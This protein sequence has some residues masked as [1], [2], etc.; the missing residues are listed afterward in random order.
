MTDLLLQR[1]S[2]KQTAVPL[3][4]VVACVVSLCLAAFVLGAD[5]Q[6]RA[7]E[8][9]LPEVVFQNVPVG[10]AL[11]SLRRRSRELDP[12]GQGVGFLLMLDKVTA[13]TPVSVKLTD[14]SLLEAIES[15]CVL[16]GLSCRVERQAVVIARGQ[17]PPSGGRVSLPGQAEALPT[18]AAQLTGRS[19]GELREQFE[20]VAQGIRE[21]YFARRDAL[22]ER[23]VAE[24]GALSRQPQAA[25]K[26]GPVVRLRRE[27][28]RYEQEKNVSQG[29]FSEDV[30]SLRDLQ[31]AYAGHF[32][33]LWKT[34]EKRGEELLRAYDSRLRTEEARRT[35]AGD[36]VTALK[37][38]GER[39]RARRLVSGLLGEELFRL[40][41]ADKPSKEWLSENLRFWRH[42]RNKEKGRWVSYVPKEEELARLEARPW[43]NMSTRQ[44]FGGWRSNRYVVETDLACD[45]TEYGATVTVAGVHVVLRAG[46]IS[47]HGRRWEPD[48][49]VHLRDDR[50]YTFRFEVEPTRVICSVDGRTVGTYE[51]PNLTRDHVTLRGRGGKLACTRLVVHRFPCFREQ[52]ATSARAKRQETRR[53]NDDDE[54]GQPDDGLI[55]L[56]AAAIWDEWE[57]G[58][59]DFLERYRGKAFATGGVMSG[60]GKGIG[61]QYVDLHN[62]HVR[63]VFDDGLMSPGSAL[64]RLIDTYKHTNRRSRRD[65]DDHRDR[66][67]DRVLNVQARGICRGQSSGRIVIE[68]CTDLK[69]RRQRGEWISDD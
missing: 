26:L 3:K 33:E 41:T 65:R 57:K 53:R 10:E 55:R 60:S 37:I 28:E 54:E 35:Q 23:Y 50:T 61:V 58:M 40:D 59:A 15:V 34:A 69:W 14:V 4:T 24:V 1:V 17:D 43:R 32:E 2:L 66:D 44:E 11:D 51:S 6:T 46:G 62:D 20:G 42:E 18:A 27:Q 13:A 39:V 52:I 9:L 67:E 45:L 48:A 5:V 29:A 25:G 19:A 21:E 8:I 30:P 22:G 68:G 7:R 38:R 47:I 31:R 63:L 12:G 16:A 56:G 36:V 49:A 64:T